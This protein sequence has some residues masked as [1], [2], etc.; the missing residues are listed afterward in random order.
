[1]ELRKIP[2]PEPDHR[3]NGFPFRRQR[4]ALFTGAYNHIADG[5]SLTLNRLVGY[6]ERRGHEVLVF[7]PT[8]DEPAID[9]NGTMEEVRSFAMPGRSDYRISVGL[10]AA[11]RRSLDEFDPTLFHIATPDLLGYQALKYAESRGTPVVTSYHTHFSSYLK[12]YGM[13]MFETS[14][15]SYLRWFYGQCRHVYVP[16]PSMAD[17][18]R[19]HDISDGIRIWPRGVETDLFKPG[20]RSLEWRRRMGFGDH[21]I[22]VTFVSRL[23]LEKGLGVYADVI[24]KLKGE[25]LPIHSL[26]VGDGPARGA[27]ERRLPRAVFGGYLEGEELATAYASSDIFL[28]PSDTETFGNVTLEAMASGLAAVCADATG[29]K[30]LVV[31]GETGCLAPPGDVDAFA[32]HVRALIEQPDLRADMSRKARARAEDFAWPRILARVERYYMEALEKAPA[33]NGTFRSVRTPAASFS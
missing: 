14:M 24:Q 26:I 11:N 8:D 4:I 10:S 19:A 20:R 3:D 29:A 25:G 6:L 32:R 16:A 17:V 21:E 9:H 30:D 15:W 18:L 2:A 1:M 22:I 5:V 33:T 12:Y 23:V 7:A 27:L 13:G 28:F 31:S